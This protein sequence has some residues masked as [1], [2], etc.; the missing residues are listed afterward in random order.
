M[1]YALAVIAIVIMGS[2]ALR[3]QEQ[4]A[5]MAQGAPASVAEC[6]QAQARADRTIDAANRRL[7]TARQSNSPA[8][9]RAS[10][11]E[12]Q[13]A[14]RQLRAEIAPCANLQG[15]A[16]AAD[17][18]AGHVMPMP[19]VKQATPAAPG[20]PVMRP[21]STTPAPGAVAPAAPAPGGAADPHAGH[22]MPGAPAAPTTV[23]RTASPSTTRTTKP[24]APAA[25]DPHAGM[26]MP[27]APATQTPRSAPATAAPR[28]TTPPPAAAADPHAGMKMPGTK[29]EMAT[30]PAMTTVNNP[31]TDPAKLKCA[32]KV[33]PRK[34]PN[35]TYLGRTYYFCSEA[36]RAEFA[37]DPAKYFKAP[38]K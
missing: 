16:G 12:M 4:M 13:A 23:P 9:M 8:A 20:T 38:G 37:K 26:K 27:A 15:A 6:A 24:A 7:E 36:D 33:D 22:V 11:D 19:N 28:A 21:G 30:T 31:V 2:D 29:P 32:T 34:A 5:G 3:A 35:V 25:A 1:R 17:P 18:H 10:V 14:L